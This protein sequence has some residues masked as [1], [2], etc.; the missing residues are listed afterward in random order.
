M[1][2]YRDDLQPVLA[3]CGHGLFHPLDVLIEQRIDLLCT[4]N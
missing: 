3:L 2:Q 1:G 4:A